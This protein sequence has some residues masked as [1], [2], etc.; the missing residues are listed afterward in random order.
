M[1][2]ICKTIGR[3]SSIRPSKMLSTAGRGGG[4]MSAME[5]RMQGEANRHSVEADSTF[6]MPVRHQP[7]VVRVQPLRLIQGRSRTV[8][9]GE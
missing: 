8:S 3:C 9:T 6:L 1:V 4:A 7:D 5:L 2:R